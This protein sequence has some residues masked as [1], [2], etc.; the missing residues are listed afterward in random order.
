M[1]GEGSRSGNER[2]VDERA[3]GYV[4]KTRGSRGYRTGEYITNAVSYH[5]VILVY[6]PSFRNKILKGNYRVQRETDFNEIRFKFYCNYQVR[7]GIN[8][9]WKTE[10]YKQFQA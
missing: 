9:K 1:N 7:C 4:K 8:K 6:P 10:R 2:S 3:K 5:Y